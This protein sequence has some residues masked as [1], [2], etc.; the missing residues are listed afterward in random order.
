MYAPTFHSPQ[1]QKDQFYDDLMCTI[2]FVCQDDLL[3]VIGDFNA[4][5][6]SSHVGPDMNGMVLGVTME[7]VMLLALLTF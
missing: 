7:L 5:V 3:L 1:E 4:R 6:G 2:N